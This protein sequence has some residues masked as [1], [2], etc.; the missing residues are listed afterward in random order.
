M[1]GRCSIIGENCVIDE[2]LTVGDYVLI[3][4]G[5]LISAKEIGDDCVIE[6]AAVLGKGSVIG[7]NCKICAGEI[8]ASNE[9]IPHGTV[10]FG[11][12]QRR[13]DKSP[14]VSFV[15]RSFC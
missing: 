4:A 6:S 2:T 8:I 15:P 5:C 14:L 7:D 9:V 10:V 3:E 12:G 13:A 1:L 11:N